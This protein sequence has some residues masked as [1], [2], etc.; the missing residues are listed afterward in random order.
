LSVKA[1]RA[2]GPV[3]YLSVKALRAEGPVS[4]LSTAALRAQRNRYSIKKN[5]RFAPMF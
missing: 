2:E 5:G 1:L 3:S 4:Y